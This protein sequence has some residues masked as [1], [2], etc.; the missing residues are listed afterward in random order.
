MIMMFVLSGSVWAA[1]PV[2][3]GL[4]IHLEAD[5]ITGA[6][7]GSRIATWTGLVGSGMDAVQPTADSQPVYVASNP[8]FKG[9]A[10]VQFDGTNDW[11]DLPSGSNC[12]FHVGSFTLIAVARFN[13]VNRAQ[14]LVA[15]QAG[16]AN[17]RLR[18]M[19]DWLNSYWAFHWRIGSTG[20][21]G[22]I[23]ASPDTQV[24]IFGAGSGDGI[25]EGF[26][27][28]VSVG[29][30]SNSSTLQPGDFNIGCFKGTGSFLSGDVAEFILFN[31]KLTA[32][33]YAQVNDFLRAKYVPPIL[34][35]WTPL[36]DTIA[37]GEKTT[38]FFRVFADGSDAHHIFGLTE[39]T[40]SA[41]VDWDNFRAHCRL[42]EGS[43]QVRDGGDYRSLFAVAPCQWYNVWFVIDRTDPV[44]G[45]YFD[46]YVNQGIADAAFSDL[47]WTGSDFRL[48]TPEPLRS[49][50]AATPDQAGASVSFDNIHV[51]AGEDL[52][53]PADF[54]EPPVAP[55]N[56]SAISGDGQIS[57]GWDD[58]READ[59]DFYAVYRRT[60]PD[61]T[62]TQI[63]TAIAQSHFVDNMVTNGI[64]YYYVVSAV[65]VFGNESNVSNQAWTT[66]AAQLPPAIN[67]TRYMTASASSTYSASFPARYAVDG[68][69]NNESRWMSAD[70]T[71]PHWL[72]VQLADAF[73]VGSA[74]IFFGVD[75]LYPVSNFSLQYWTGS[76]WAAIPGATIVGNT[77]TQVQMVFSNPVTANR[78]RFY[79]DD[80]GIVRIKELAVF[81]P[82]G[83]AGFPIDT[84]VD[85]QVAA[86]PMVTADSQ[87]TSNVRPYLAT[88]GFV[89]MSSRWASAWGTGGHWLQL[90]FVADR[91]IAYAHV[92]TGNGDSATAV[93][94]FHLEYWDGAAWQTIGGTTVSGN[95]SPALSLTFSSSVTT[96]SVRLV[97]S[98]D[99]VRVRELVLLPPNHGVGYPLGTSVT[100]GAPPT[101]KWDDYADNF[102]TISNKV[103]G[104]NLQSVP[105]GSVTIEKSDKHFT[106]HYNILLNIGTDT[107]RIFN[108]A[109]ERC[110]EVVGGS[111]RAGAAV[112]EADYK[113]MPFQQWRINTAASP[114]VELVNVYSG[115]ALTVNGDGTAAGAGLIQLPSFDS[116]KQLW[117]LVYAARYPKKGV[118]QT[119]MTGAFTDK[120]R[121]SHY[122]NWRMTP[123]SGVGS[124]H[125]IPMKWGDQRADGVDHWDK[126]ALYRPVW[127]TA[128]EPL[129][130]MGFNE[131]DHD[132]QSAIP[133]TRALNLW[134]RMEKTKLPLVSPGPSWWNNSWST[135]FFSQAQACGLRYERTSIHIYLTGGPNPDDFMNIC[136]N[137]YNNYGRRPVWVSEWNL[138]NWGGAASWTAD[139]MYTFMAEVLWRMEEAYYVDRHQFFP[140]NYYWVNGQPG[141]IE[142]D[143]AILPL[144]RLF[145]AWDGDTT[146][147]E[148]TEYIL[149]NRGNHRRMKNNAGVP[150]VDAIA[151][152]DNSVKWCLVSAQTPGTFYLV[153]LADGQRFS[154]NGSQ[155]SMAAAGT[156]GSNVEWKYVS[157]GNG[158]YY[159]EHPATNRRLDSGAT[160]GNLAMF[161]NTNT[162]N[163]LRWFFVK[164]YDKNTAVINRPV[165][166]SATFNNGQI[167]L[168]WNDNSDALLGGYNVYRSVFNNSQYTLLASDVTSSQYTD[169]KAR[170]GKRFY[171]RVT[172][173]DYL[174]RESQLSDET[175]ATH[176][177]GDLTDDGIVNMLDLA[178]LGSGW[179]TG[180][181]LQTLLHIA[182]D[183]LLDTSLLV[184][185]PLDGNANDVSGNGY[186]GTVYG[187]P[188]WTSGVSGGALAFDGTADYVK[189]DGYKGILGKTARTVSAWIKSP[190]SGVNMAIASWGAAVSGQ[191]YLFGIFA[192]GGVVVYS[193]GPY[194]KTVQ[195]ILDDQWHHV[196]VVLPNDGSPS[197]G[198]VQFYIDGVRQTN[199]QFTADA[200]I[201]T[202]AAEDLLIG[203]VSM[204]PGQAT[205]FFQGFIDDIRVYDSAL[206]E[207]EIQEI[208]ARR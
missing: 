198:E 117:E 52:R 56:L 28:G 20:W 47:K 135:T 50:G 146:V 130:Y 162:W 112:R 174:N 107:Y 175:T 200:A 7:N 75:D 6:S 150:N 109:T 2:T 16:S 188:I 82:N 166:L 49:F 208:M 165:N 128:N 74:N 53:N 60:A 164:P 202:V 81:P 21:P 71:N 106:Q 102:Y 39:Q 13:A 143:G 155:L 172:A 85:L 123:S 17:D 69:V 138:V 101:Q 189:V 136:W 96:R 113:A 77:S 196:A 173:V 36:S 131:P 206:T 207:M 103:F 132:A 191:Q 99:F 84:L 86:T 76:S 90:D 171:Y 141:A 108:R 48:A 178:E 203:A 88:D 94:N 59:L 158:F 133:V 92:Y 204:S 187:N 26:L 184:H 61:G 122:Y 195:G 66:P 95:T 139:E 119:N 54:S 11:M 129:Y 23:N 163:T 149:H 80:N 157:A 38:V 97:S 65:D 41:A 19:V 151:A 45:D 32:E 167:T 63:A 55:K 181:D 27:D 125:F 68:V 89:D 46:V 180:Y 14:Y 34:T 24:H 44:N 179:Q 192:D 79:S 120:Y 127:T 183:W 5:S 62:F 185:W 93:R 42:Y 114:Y 25:A 40:S 161:A 142:R 137:S 98:D 111:L 156:T 134:S 87:D 70:T 22:A 160:T 10:T 18:I 29:T 124:G 12:P 30:A 100:F 197:L 176:Y 110:L 186:H 116:P 8:L 153:S 194:A 118:G 154:Y 37:V 57:L 190:G 170:A 145:G 144:G 9:H 51:T 58:N 126:D 91:K 148:N 105:N 35:S 147:R 193:A 67:L 72:E 33:E 15:G 4:V 182:D 152:D 177:H 205:A 83:A 104:L 3:D 159:L 169:T 201:H 1:L 121:V 31:R 115:L 78:I 140:F 73:E 43:F 168:D 64:M 199:I